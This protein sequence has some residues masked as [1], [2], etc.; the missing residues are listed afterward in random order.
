M[1]LKE[2]RAEKLKY[3]SAIKNDKR[4]YREYREHQF[5][6][7]EKYDFFLEKYTGSPHWLGESNIAAIVREAIHFYDNKEYNLICYCIM[8]N[9]VHLVVKPIVEE[10]PGIVED[11]TGDGFAKNYL[12]TKILQKLKRYTSLKCN[13]LLYRSG[14]FWQHESY[15]H[16]V[17]NNE[18]LN[19]IIEY[20]LNNPVKAELVDEW[21]RWEWS[22]CKYEIG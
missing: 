18:E 15:D 3:L 16:T 2:E 4:K 17:R 19:R 7:F 8:P 12:L 20:V 9:H 21:D 11:E 10:N 14:A 6:Y 1:Q 5:T 22:Y 13:K